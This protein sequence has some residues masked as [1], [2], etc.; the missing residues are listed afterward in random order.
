MRR[1]RR[2]RAVGDRGTGPQTQRRNAEELTAQEIQIARLARQGLSN[3]EIGARLLI[4][5]HTVAYH[6]RKVFTKLDITSRNQIDAV[7]RD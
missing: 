5:R 1:P 4:S 2:A 3:A 6:L 7:H